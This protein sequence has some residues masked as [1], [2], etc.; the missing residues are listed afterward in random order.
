[1]NVSGHLLLLSFYLDNSREH[2]NAMTF[3]GL[4]GSFRSIRL[5]FYIR[6][7]CDKVA[8]QNL[9]SIGLP[10]SA[11]RRASRGLGHHEEVRGRCYPR[12]AFNPNFLFLSPQYELLCASQ[13]V[14][15]LHSILSNQLS[16]MWS[17]WTSI[18]QIAH[19]AMFFGQYPSPRIPRCFHSAKFDLMNHPHGTCE[20]ARAEWGQGEE[21][22]CLLLW[23][24]PHQK[25]KIYCT[26][27]W[28]SWRVMNN[29]WILTDTF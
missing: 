16:L 26:A 15:R 10:W 20:R 6:T 24:M 25:G 17:P 3:L 5:K 1:M 21:E 27:M 29:S 18:G 2:S 11:A 22:E 13:T 28:K 14:L 7:F 4:Q 8:A 9:K 12:I 23:A 19:T